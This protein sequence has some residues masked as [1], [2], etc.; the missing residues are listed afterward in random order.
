MIVVINARLRQGLS[1]FSADQIHIHHRLLAKGLSQT[2]TALLIYSVTLWTAT[3]GLICCGIEQPWIYFIPATI[4]L[5][6]MIWQVQANRK[7]EEKE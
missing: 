1:P 3:L 6:I 5:L 2:T 7:V 4:L